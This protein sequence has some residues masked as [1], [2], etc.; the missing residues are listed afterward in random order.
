MTILALH[1]T[2]ILVI[3]HLST[4]KSTDT[5][6]DSNSLLWGVG[7]KYVRGK[8]NRYFFN[9]NVN[10]R[11]QCLVASGSK[12]SKDKCSNAGALKWGLTQVSLRFKGLFSLY[13]WY[14]M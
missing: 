5:G 2:I 6:Q 7:I 9:F 13:C 1:N 10:E 14:L 4:P 12:I 11:S 8:A 3:T